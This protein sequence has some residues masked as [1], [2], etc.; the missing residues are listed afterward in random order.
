MAPACS[1]TPYPRSTAPSPSA[2][3]LPGRLPPTVRDPA[4]A[5][6]AIP[7]CEPA[8]ADRPPEQVPVRLQH[9]EAGDQRLPTGPRRDALRPQ[10]DAAVDAAYA[11][12]RD[13]LAALGARV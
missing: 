5:P 13:R 3:A 11:A 8:Y 6:P 1:A 12:T 10:P 7:G 2:S 4:L 9:R